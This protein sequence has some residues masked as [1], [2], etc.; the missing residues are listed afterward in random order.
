LRD[1]KALGVG[2]A[3][4][5]FGTGYS[6]LATLRAFPFDKLKVDRSFVRDL[7]EGSESLAIINAILGLGRGLRMPVVVEGVETE[8]QAEILR[9]CGCDEMQGYLLGRPASIDRFALITDPTGLLLPPR[10]TQD[11]PVAIA[12]QAGSD[13]K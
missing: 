5:D 10:N 12:A 9:R 2:I 7:G 11:D 4:D 1:I 8:V 6:S 3:M 13:C